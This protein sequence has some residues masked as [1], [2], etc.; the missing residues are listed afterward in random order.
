[1]IKTIMMIKDTG[2][3]DNELLWAQSTRTPEIFSLAL[4]GRFRRSLKR[5]H[6]LNGQWN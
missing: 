3:D 5:I 2:D 1:M 6:L 4:H